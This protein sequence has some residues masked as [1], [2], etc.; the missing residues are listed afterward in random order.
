MN[1]NRQRWIGPSS[2]LIVML[3]AAS[4]AAA[5]DTSTDVQRQ[6]QLR[7]QQQMELRL[8][9]QHQLDRSTRPPQTPSADFQMRQL[10]RDQQQ[11]LQQFHDQQLRGAIA[12]SAPATS[13]QMR[14]DLERQRAL[15]PGVGELNRF[16]SQPQLE[17]FERGS[18]P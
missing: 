12:P 6:L 15:R 11:R 1:T 8:K 2:A 14:R 13:E 4:Q 7:E 10:D 18:P 5:A 9:M 17:P 16:G 3:I